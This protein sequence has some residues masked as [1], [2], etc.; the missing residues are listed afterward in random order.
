M[1]TN[2]QI[3]AERVQ[4]YNDIK[5][6]RVGDYLRLPHGIYTRFTHNWGEECDQIQTGGSSGS[7]YY[8]GNS[9][10]SYSGSLDSGVKLSELRETGETKDGAIWF[11]DG[12]I[13][14]AGRGKYYSIP[15]RV[16]EP[17]E[18]AD[19]AG[20]PQIKAYEK[21]QFLKTVD[22][23]T[24][25]NGNGQ[26]YTLPLP[27]V[28]IKSDNI[29]DVA[30]AHIKENTGLEFTK[31]TWAGYKA[32]PVKHEQLTTLLLT[33]DFACKYYNNGS[34]ENTLYLEFNR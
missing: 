12:D 25:I 23:I 24:R 22:T 33:Y 18:G 4:A 21:A 14:G 1:R 2:E 31:A 19:L 34:T 15:F 30:L 28:V 16:F 3:L 13:S 29:N 26:P 9:Y 32:Q 8:L 6:P 10:C 20:C 7:S 5:G 11:F 27:E 17:V